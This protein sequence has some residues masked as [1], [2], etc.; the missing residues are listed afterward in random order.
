MTGAG[1]PT[2]G[3]RLNDAFGRFGRLSV[4]IDPHP[5][6]L[7]AW[8]LSDDAAGLREF[9]LRVV[10]AAAGQAGIVK[11]QVAFFE[12]YGSR[13][14]AA[15]EEVIA[16]ARAAG[17]LVIAD[18]KRGDVGTSVEAYGETWL[19]PGSPLEADAV[20]L[21]AYQGVGSLDAPIRLAREHGK[22]VFVLAATSNPEGRDIQRAVVDAHPGSVAEES[23]AAS[24]GGAPR[25]VAR[26][27]VDDI[28]ASN[29]AAGETELG[30]VGVVIGATLRL[31][32]FQLDFRPSPVLPVLA[33]GFGHQGAAVS[34]SADIF[35]P[36]SPGVIV[37]QSR[38]VL[39][40]GPTGIAAAIKNQAKDVRSNIA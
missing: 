34:Q 35:G 23:N 22:G 37:A 18:A 16:A 29:A 6:L 28:V 4:G 26:A 31:A 3:D 2:F 24:D 20:T 14:Y 32:E 12:R 27:I 15:L 21:V 1:T 19:R 11:P 25:R 5:Y 40:A 33:P 9:G 39:D 30:S 36:M 8:G 17:L 10:E 13:G 7:S 38:S